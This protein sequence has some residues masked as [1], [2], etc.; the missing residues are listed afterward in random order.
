MVQTRSS[1]DGGETWSNE[2]N[3][4]APG[5]NALYPKI[6]LI[7]AGTLVA[8]W[9]R[10]D[11]SDEII[12]SSASNDGGL[13]WSNPVDLSAPG[14]DAYNPQICVASAGTVIACWSRDRIIQSASSADG[15]LTW[16]TP[17]SV[18]SPGGDAYNPQM[19]FDAAGNIVAIWSLDDGGP[20]TIQS[21]SSADGGLTWSTPLGLSAPD[22]NANFPRIC[23]NAAGDIVA[24]WKRSN[25]TNDIIQS[26]ASTDS[27]ATW[28]APVDLSAPRGDASYPKIS[29]DA[30][31][32]VIAIWHR[33]DGR[34]SR[35]QSNSSS[36]GGLT[37]S[38]PVEHSAPENNASFPMIAMSEAGHVSAIWVSNDGSDVIAQS[39][40]SSN[41]GKTWS[42][43]VAL[44]ASGG[45]ASSPEITMDAAGKTFAVWQRADWDNADGETS[46]QFARVL[47]GP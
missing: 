32:N 1:R 14:G 4:S 13:T 31:R 40:S 47:K 45:D 6:S 5:C 15:G 44:S 38:T 3:L 18:S 2:V 42:T 10:S 23:V 27:G 41:G 34:T 37:W 21:S 9:R 28:S 8:I 30:A 25:G 36:D 26:S 19:S 39:S 16:S 24:I 22:G 43:P 17:V 29:M 35:V 11:D 33:T 20:H 12:Q 46:I 7:A